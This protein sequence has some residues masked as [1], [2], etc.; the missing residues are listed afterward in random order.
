MIGGALDDTLTGNTLAN[1]LTGGAGNDTLTGG[2]GG[3]I[4]R[5][6][7]SLNAST[8][9]DAIT[10][11]SLAEGDSI[12]LENAIFTALPTTGILAASAFLIGATAITADQRILY[13]S[14]T[15]SLAYDAD[16]V[17][18][19]SAISFATISPGLALTNT[20]FVVT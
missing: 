19:G 2:L 1:K 10:D 9:R 12:Q 18:S 6:D 11:F 16:G 15:G 7:S 13:N 3:D 17:G 5:F 8:N 20:F 4:F 14:T